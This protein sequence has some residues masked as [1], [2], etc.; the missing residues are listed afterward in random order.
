MQLAERSNRQVLLIGT[1]GSAP[2]K[3]LFF[4]KYRIQASPCT[5]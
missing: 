3:E 4:R 1:P 2:L 5:Y